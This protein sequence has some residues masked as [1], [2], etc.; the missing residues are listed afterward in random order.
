MIGA[1]MNSYSS[2]KDNI[3]CPL[4]NQVRIS[5]SRLVEDDGQSEHVPVWLLPFCRQSLPR[6]GLDHSL[7]AK[8]HFVASALAHRDQPR[9]TLHSGW[10][11]C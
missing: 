9:W 10:S 5:L 3:D 11:P 1:R 7:Q 4:W 6:D 2:R 8:G